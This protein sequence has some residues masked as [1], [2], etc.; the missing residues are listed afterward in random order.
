MD[1]PFPS[2]RAVTFNIIFREGS[3]HCRAVE[4]PHPS[5][6]SLTYELQ[7]KG[8][9]RTPYSRSADGLSKVKAAI[10]AEVPD[11]RIEFFVADA[12][13]PKGVEDAVNGTVKSFGRIDIVTAGA[14]KC[15]SWLKRT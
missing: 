14:G 2:V 1:A 7:L 15:D 11:A 8:A 12:T 6:P 4:T 9:G 3:K 13:D 5:D 10:L